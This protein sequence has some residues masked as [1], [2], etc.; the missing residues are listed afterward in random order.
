MYPLIDIKYESPYHRPM[1][2]I[3][4]FFANC[5]KAMEGLLAAE[6]TSLGATATK[7]TVTGVY[8]DAPLEAAYRICLWS[9]LANHVLLPIDTL[10]AFDTP[11]LLR[12]IARMP[13]A[14]HMSADH[15]FKVDFSGQSD[16]IHHTLYGSQLVKDGIVDYFRARDG[17]RPSID[18]VHPDIV[19]NAHLYG[20]KL[21]LSLDLSGQS[22]HK[23]GY[24]TATGDA[25]LKENL[26][27]AILYRA[28]F[29]ERWQEYAY[30]IDPLCGTGTLLIEAALIATDTAPGLLRHSFG[31]SAWKQHD[32]N[33]WSTL[34]TEAQARH[35]LGMKRVLPDFL[36]YDGS[37]RA[38]V[39]AREHID[40][41]GLSKIVSVSVR[42]LNHLTPPTHA[43]AKP[44][45]LVTNPPYGERLGDEE[46]LYPLYEHLG[47]TLRKDFQGWSAA[48]FTGNA[49]L[50]KATR[51]RAKKQYA[52][53]NGSIPC[54]LLLMDI[55]PQWFMR[56]REAPPIMDEAPAEEKTLDADAQMFANR[57]KKNLKALKPWV[58]ANNITCYRIYDADMPEY[59]AAIDYYDGWAHVQEY[60]APKTI[61]PEKAEHRLY[62]M[63]DTLPSVLGIPEDHVIV[64]QRRRQ[65][66]FTQYQR[67]DHR[68]QF[69]TVTEG[70]CKLSV[71][72]H[73]YLD[74]GLFLDH[75]PMRLQIAKLA[76]GKRFLNLYCYTGA[77]TVHAALGGAY[78]TV[79]VDM[80]GTYTAWARRNLSMNGLSEALHRVIQADCYAWLDTNQDMFDLIF[81]DPPTFSRSK[82]M[83]ADF[84]IQ[85]DHI[86]L[87][88]KTL[89]HLAEGGVLYFSNNF[90]PFIFD[91]EA[92]PDYLVEDI[93]PSTIDKDF[94]R[95]PKIHHC[96]RIT[97]R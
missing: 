11:S 91:Y 44:G 88:D 28:G 71:N 74:T 48:L 85:R 45:F 46:A 31:F 51:I 62:T 8:F 50:G 35:E 3:L 87:I 76:K 36:G 96:F 6:L 7:E 53:W 18:T 47:A 60:A 13:W 66:D 5:P 23:R 57:L 39:Q 54:K 61:D 63:V 19:I 32:A 14:E 49:N 43:G 52:F 83:D 79:S 42:E 97:R 94:A 41:A 24:R 10:D 90:R 16:L 95:N 38:V 9:R 34:L 92:Y 27:A 12:N 26:A 69:F 70:Q 29:P 81:L 72:L 1:L 59:S 20:D 84:D 86:A 25:P 4:R 15:T 2:K 21:T 55:D 64:K 58:N 78:R 77:V 82:R 65:K 33:L 17:V 73:D 75:R 68:D 93:S 30:V 56:D 37:P 22:L 40:N 89:R 67:M 80:S